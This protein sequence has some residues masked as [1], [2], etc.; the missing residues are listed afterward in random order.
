[1]AL[2][3]VKILIVDDEIF[4]RQVLRAVLEKIGFTVVG[5]AG[6]GAEALERYRALRPHIVIMDIYMPD[7]NGIDATKNLLAFDPNARVLMASA[8]DFDS[9][10][11]AALDAGAKGILMK[12]FV[13]KEI[14]EMIRK[15][16]TGK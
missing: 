10:T 7:M 5:E 3:D 8:S 12:P 2:K 15:L 6:D 1:M 9:D 16:L 11:Q 13:P 14:Y 4:F